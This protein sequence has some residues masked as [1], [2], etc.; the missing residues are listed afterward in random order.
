LV[1]STK[2]KSA[3]FQSCA[4][5]QKNNDLIDTSAEVW[6]HGRMLHEDLQT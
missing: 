3:P 6:R 1:E 2:S 4:L 5:F